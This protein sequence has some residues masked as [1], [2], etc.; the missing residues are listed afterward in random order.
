M[1]LPSDWLSQAQCRAAMFHLL[2]IW[3]IADFTEKILH[4]G[5]SVACDH[6]TDSTLQFFQ[7]AG[8]WVAYRTGWWWS[9]SKTEVRQSVAGRTGAPWGWSQV[10]STEGMFRVHILYV[11]ICTT[12]ISQPKQNMLTCVFNS[13]TETVTRLRA[14]RS[15]IRFPA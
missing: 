2:T 14:G 6:V 3:M 7:T 9:T 8:V 12:E 15:R 1:Q 5:S 10:S 4:L 13:F 11:A